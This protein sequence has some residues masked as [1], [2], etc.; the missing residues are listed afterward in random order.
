MRFGRNLAF[1][2]LLAPDNGT[3][4]EPSGGAAPPAGGASPQPGA[5]GGGQ[6]SGEGGATGPYR[7]DG[8]PDHLFGTSERETLDKVWGA[9]RPA[10]DEIAK[11]GELGKLPK[12]ETGYSFEPSEKVKPYLAD[13]EKDPV[14]KVVREAALKSGIR[15][16]QF[17][18]FIGTIME[19]MI[20]GDMVQ[21]PVDLDAER[22]ALLPAEAKGLDEAGQKAAVDKR[23]RDNHARLD[24][25]KARGL[26]E[27]AAEALGLNLDTAAGN[28]AI[29]WIAEATRTPQPTTGGNPTGGT[30]HEQVK[31]RLA[32]PRGKVG[33]S[34]Y[35]KSFADETD[36]MYQS[37]YPN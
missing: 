24:L 36:R 5:A 26:D 13:I 3:G 14:M 8:L 7:P 20:D 9:Y 2:P 18:P 19:A 33:H 30:T 11:F 23:V 17:T 35:E 37:L 10:R 32:D 15:D 34:K 29:E 31:A 21:P 4:S 12:D 16:K 6:P 1:M 27:K 28:K 25:F 22:A